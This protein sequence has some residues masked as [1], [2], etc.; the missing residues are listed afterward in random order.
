MQGLSRESGGNAQVSAF[1]AYAAA[2]AAAVGNS[3]VQTSDRLPR[4][5]QRIHVD[6]V[7]PWPNAFL[8][9]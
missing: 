1:V 9:Y 8:S 2:A 5:T 7:A 3:R 6:V 4:E